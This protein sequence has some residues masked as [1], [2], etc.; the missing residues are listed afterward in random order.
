VIPS[1]GQQLDISGSMR[2][3]AQVYLDGRLIETVYNQRLTPLRVTV[4]LNSSRSLSSTRLQLVVENMGRSSSGLLDEQRKGFEGLV[5]VDGKK[6][7]SRWDHFSVDMS[8]QLLTAIRHSKHWTTSGRSKKPVQ[9]LPT[10]YRGHFKVKRMT[11][12]YIDM[13]KWTKGVV[14]V[15]GFV[16]GRYWSIG[17]QQ[18]LYVPSPILSHGE[19]EILVFELERTWNAKVKFISRSSTNLDHHYRKYRGT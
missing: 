16:L 14:V 15:N 3:R 6:I 17:P 11:D 13:T 10:F 2:D 9:R 1:D 12:T 18:S 7:E 8:K 19:N 4:A 5:R